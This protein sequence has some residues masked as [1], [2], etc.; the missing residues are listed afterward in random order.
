M[1]FYEVA[2]LSTPNTFT[3]KS[4]Y[5]LNLYEFVEVKV[6]S[7]IKSGFIV[8]EVSKPSFNCKSIIL[9]NSHSLIK[10]NNL[11]K[12][13]K[14][15]NNKFLT[16]EYFEIASFISS[17]YFSSLSESIS[18]FTP[19]IDNKKFPKIDI[20]TDI[21]LSNKQKEAFDFVNK[22]QT[23]IIF[24]DTGSGKTEIY[25]KLIEQIINQNK[26]AILL[27]PEISIT[28]QIEKRLVKVFGDLVGIWHSKMSKKSREKVLERIYNGDVRVVVGARSALFLPM[29]NLNLIIIDESHDDSYKS[30]SMP[31]Y[32]AKDLAIYFANKLNIKVVLGSATPL[33]SDLYKFPYFRLKGTYFKTRKVISF[34]KN[35]SEDIFFK[36]DKVLESNKQVIIVIPTRGSFK[37]MICH[38]C[39]EVLKCPYCDVAMSVHYDEKRVK[40]HYCNFISMIPSNCSKCNSEVFNNSRIGTTEVVE[41]LKNRFPNYKIEKFDRDSVTTKTKLDTT[42]KKFNNKEIGILVG[43]QMLSKGHDY[44]GVSLSIILDIDF[45]L[46]IADFRAKERALALL[47]QVSGRSGRKEN[48]ETIVVTNNKGF[49]EQSYEDFFKNELEFRKDLNYPPFSKLA[50]LEFSDKFDKNAEKQMKE[51][52]NCLKKKNINII[53]FGASPIK[54]ISNQYR[55]QIL[56]KGEKFHSP[57]YECKSEFVK[58]DFDPVS[59][60]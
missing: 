54:R 21:N 12:T 37:Y 9:K 25:I 17:Y 36:I 59:M 1:Y 60:F 16:K 52:L 18:L 48:G 45:V 30:S 28:S 39:G 34:E 24:G 3:Y 42:L 10:K 15:F 6:K 26:T 14:F 40:C 55:Y 46:A 57:L 11:I 53:G 31:K 4:L 20:Q 8:K 32:N 2:I 47:T 27:L 35:L 49:F 5:K 38:E 23:S 33:V 22:N 50:L 29:K 58:I 41:I 7:K 44:H 19:F 13:D 56:V 43:T 51:V